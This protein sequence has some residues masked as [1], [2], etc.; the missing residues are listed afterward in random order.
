MY[1]PGKIH[2]VAYALLRLLDITN[3]QMCLIKPQMQVYFTQRL[4]GKNDIKDFLKIRQFEGTL[5]VQQ[6]QKLVRK[7]KPS[8]MKNGELYRMGQD[9]RL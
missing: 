5:C 1:K 9:N 7:V 4:N 6:K 3:P 8:T 2:V